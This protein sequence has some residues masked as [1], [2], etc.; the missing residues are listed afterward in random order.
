MNKDDDL[1]RVFTGSVI[2]AEIIKDILNDNGIGAL[3][4]NT[5]RESTV[6]GWVSGSFEDACR[7]FVASKHYEKAKQLVDNFLSSEN[8]NTN[9]K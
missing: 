1:I 9:S 3:V 2:D 6:A 8:Q 5:L 4:R 7:V